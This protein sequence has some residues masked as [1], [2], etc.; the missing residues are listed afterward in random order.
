MNNKT[1]FSIQTENDGVKIQVEGTAKDLIN[2]LANA[3]DD[4]EEIE[5]VVVLALMAVQL[6][7]ESEDGENNALTELFSR[8]SP[9]AQA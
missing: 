7:K 8:M 1:Q 2:L 4:N 9:K 5:R 3:I 6:K